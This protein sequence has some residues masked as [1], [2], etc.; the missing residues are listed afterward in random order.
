MNEGVEHAKDPN[1][2]T[3]IPYAGPHAQHGAKVMIHLQRGGWLAFGQDDDGVHHL[4]ELGK[5][6]EEAIR[7][8]GRVPQGGIGITKSVTKGACTTRGGGRVENQVASDGRGHFGKGPGRVSGQ[9][10]IV[11][12]HQTTG[13]GRFQSITTVRTSKVEVGDNDSLRN[14]TWP[15]NIIINPSKSI[16]P[17]HCNIDQSRRASTG[18]W[19]IYKMLVRRQRG[20]R[21]EVMARARP[22][23]SAQR[24]CWPRR[25][26]EGRPW[27]Q[28][29][30]RRKRRVGTA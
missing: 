19:Q 9:H 5:V 27:C 30:R 25:G 1:G 23:V 14:G 6:K 16:C 4:V 13:Q 28:V 3:L 29:M 7:G 22:S 10:E 20:D 12:R 15:F 24:R 17:A 2:L 11:Q 18:A 21:W 8:N 26:R